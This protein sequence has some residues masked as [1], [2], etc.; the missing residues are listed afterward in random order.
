MFIRI[1]L[2]LAF[3]A[4]VL[5]ADTLRLRNGST[6]Q[7]SFVS[8]SDGVIRFSIGQR[9]NS[10]NISDVS[11]LQFENPNGQAANQTSPGQDNSSGSGNPP[12]GQ[13]NAPEAQAAAQPSPDANDAIPPGTQVV[14]RMIDSVD[15]SQAR[16]GDTFKASL[17]QPLT[18]EGKTVIP[19]GADVVTILTDSQ[20]SGKFAGKTELTLDI[21]S[22]TANGRTY[23]VRTTGLAQASNSRGNRT[24]KVVGGTAALGAIIGAIAGGGRGAAIGA[25]AG[26]ATGAGVEA[27]TAGQ[28]VQIPSE[29]RLT[30]TLKNG[31]QL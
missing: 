29:T 19:A 28:R 15:S 10:F 26:A 17:D 30:F 2:S 6:I 20:Q 12:F 16:V 4:A 31:L 22:I 23:P 13:R 8:A 25:G 9:V 14:V 27:V 21:Q 5:Q 18:A 7:G 11:S 1:A 24:A 3:C